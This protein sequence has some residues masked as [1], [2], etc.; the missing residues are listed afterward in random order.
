MAFQN[1][2]T[3]VAYDDSYDEERQHFKMYFI[4]MLLHWMHREKLLKYDI[5]NFIIIYR[6][7]KEWSTKLF[8][9]Y[10]KIWYFVVTSAG[11]LFILFYT[12]IFWYEMKTIEMVDG[13]LHENDLV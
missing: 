10:L 5:R 2:Y 12:N 9:K 4:N 8:R 3:L 7:M 11:A 6:Y 1:A 13:Q